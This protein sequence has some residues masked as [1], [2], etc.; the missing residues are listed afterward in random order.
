MAGT[1]ENP[2]F[3]HVTDFEGFVQKLLGKEALPAPAAPGPI[4]PYRSFGQVPSSIGPATSNSPGGT[5]AGQLYNWQMYQRQPDYGFSPQYQAAPG[6][7]AQEWYRRQAL[8]VA[9]HV[10]EDPQSLRPQPVGPYNLFTPQQQVTSQTYGAD[11]MPIGDTTVS[12]QTAASAA[13]R[14]A[15]NATA[16][17]L[18]S[19][20]FRRTLQ[21]LLMEGGLIP[22][23]E[24]NWRP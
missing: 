15:L 6:L 23:D 9:A 8:G 7:S 11:G 16:T 20:E 13:R 2:Y 5:G 17:Q 14:A 21:A 10:P 12:T 22:I 3:Q 4:S 18:Q 1:Q 24:A 19:E